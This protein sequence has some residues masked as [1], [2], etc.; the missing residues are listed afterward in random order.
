MSI[1]IEAQIDDIIN[2]SKKNCFAKMMTYGGELN[3][4]VATVPEL[5]RQLVLIW[6]AESD[7]ATLQQKNIFIDALTGLGL[8][9]AP[10]GNL[11]ASN[12]TTATL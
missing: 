9:T 8:T 10:L 7:Y 2:T 11:F 3:V 6:A 1:R 5:K 12:L 4:G